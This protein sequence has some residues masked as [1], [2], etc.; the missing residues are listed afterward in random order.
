MGRIVFIYIFRNCY[1][2]FF[3]K[4]YEFERKKEGIWEVLEKWE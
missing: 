4:V 2:K 1:K 3:L